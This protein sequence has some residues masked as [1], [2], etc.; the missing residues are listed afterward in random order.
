MVPFGHTVFNAPSH[1]GSP[2]LTTCAF[3]VGHRLDQYLVDPPGVAPGLA[4][5]QPAVLLLPLRT[6]T[7]NEL[8]DNE[9]FELSTSACKAEMIPFHQSPKK[10]AGMFPL[11]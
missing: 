1:L 10:M 2:R 3:C 5:C 4:D 11:H 9:R 8:V 7:F 6:R